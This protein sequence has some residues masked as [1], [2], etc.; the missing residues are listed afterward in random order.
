MPR[1][2]TRTGDEGYT[3]APLAGR[4]PKTHEC[5]EAV[6]D[7]DEA[8]S[9]LGLAA[10]I[11]RREGHEK[12]AELLDWVQEMLFRVGFQL[13]E[14][15]AQNPRRMKKCVDERDVREVERK[16]DE[17]LPEPPRG[18]TLHSGDLLAA[19]IALARSIVRRAE[20][21]IW[22][23]VSVAGR[24]SDENIRIMLKLINRLSDLLYALEYSVIARAGAGPRV[25]KC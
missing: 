3:W 6:G 21:S 25:V 14:L 18:F 12:E 1:I 19:S 23:C 10:A 2:Y 9:A 16:I 4:V 8:E 13:W 7:L 15:G 22:R 24:G 17:L 11:A 20:R 5:V